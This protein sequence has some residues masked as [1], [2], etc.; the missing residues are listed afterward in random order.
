MIR[1]TVLSAGV[2]QECGLTHTL[3]FSYSNPIDVNIT[4]TP[5]CLVCPAT[6]K[7]FSLNGETLIN[8]PPDVVIDSTTASIY[9]WSV[10]PLKLLLLN[11]I[12]CGEKGVGFTFE[13]YFFSLSKH[14][15][16]VSYDIW[17][18]A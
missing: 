13:A 15:F 6:A 8:A 14:L 9:N 11:R 4:A 1:D 10:V 5:S 18:V 3:T 12:V 7:Y 16:L 2:A 17:R